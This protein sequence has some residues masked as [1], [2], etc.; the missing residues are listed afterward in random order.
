MFSPQKYFTFDLLNF[1]SIVPKTEQLRTP[2]K[3][4]I[5][6][7]ENQLSSPGSATAETSAAGKYHDNAN[8]EKPKLKNLTSKQMS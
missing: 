2:V 3:M 1:R 8:I 6:E 4:L 5:A 7:E